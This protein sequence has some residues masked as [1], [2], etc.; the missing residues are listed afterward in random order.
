MVVGYPS[1]AFDQAV[2]LVSASTHDAGK[3]LPEGQV[4]LSLWNEC[5]EGSGVVL[6]ATVDDRL[7]GCLVMFD[8]SDQPI[9]H[10]EV[11]SLYV[12]PKYRGAGVANA[13]VEAMSH[14]L[15][16]DISVLITTSGPARPFYK[17]LG[18]EEECRI[19]TSSVSKIKEALKGV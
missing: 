11:W 16:E 4:V 9:P 8:R 15:E 1:I 6:L 19:N 7:A 12:V 5:I 18:F 3:P 14:R 2:D 10:Y 13:L 17:S